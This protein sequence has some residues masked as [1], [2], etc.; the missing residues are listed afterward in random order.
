[1]TKAKAKNTNKKDGVLDF[2]I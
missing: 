2:F 1:M